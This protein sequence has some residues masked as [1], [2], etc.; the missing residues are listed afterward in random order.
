VR[1][2]DNTESTGIYARRTP[3]FAQCVAGEAGRRV[4]AILEKYKQTLPLKDADRVMVEKRA[5]EIRARY[6]LEEGK[7]K[8]EE[9]QFD[10][11]RKLFSEANGYLHQTSLSL[12]TIVWRCAG[13]DDEAHLVLESNAAGNV[14]RRTARAAQLL[15]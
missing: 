6:L 2:L 15:L 11:A 9:R 12:A 13:R 4:L 14:A 7:S 5:A 10:Q 3:R 1:K 8:L